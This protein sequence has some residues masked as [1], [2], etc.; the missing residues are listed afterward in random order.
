MKIHPAEWA[1]YSFV[2][3]WATVRR[4][5]LFLV[6]YGLGIA[7][8]IGGLI[9]VVLLL[10]LILRSLGLALPLPAPDL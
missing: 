10:Q 1:I 8:W 6:V 4:V 3:F 5:V 7:L 2:V 9:L